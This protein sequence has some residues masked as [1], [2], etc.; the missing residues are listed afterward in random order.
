MTFGVSILYWLFAFF[1]PPHPIPTSSEIPRLQTE[2]NVG[3]AALEE[4]NLSEARRRFEA[5]RRLAPEEPLGW[6]DGAV[7]AMREK[8]LAGAK[9]L[10]AQALRLAP[11]DAR[12]LALQATLEE[13]EGNFPAAVEAAEK[14][15]SSSPRDLVSRWAAARVLSEKIAN[16]QPRALELL[17][18][19]LQEAPAN[20]FLLA[21]LFEL[22]L[23]GGDRSKAAATFE[24]LER[25]LEAETRADAK[26]ARYVSE[27]KSALDSG[28]AAAA[29]LK[30]RIVENLLRVLPRYQQARRDVDPAVVGLPLE[31]WSPAVAA[32]VRAHPR[33]IP[34]RFVERSTP[35]LAALERL[36]AVRAGGRDG[37]DLVFAGESGIAVALSRDSYRTGPPLPGSIARDVAVA[38]VA[39]SRQ[40]DLIT[41][42]G[43]WIGGR[44]SRKVPFSG[45]EHVLPFDYDND[46]DLDLY[47]TSPSGDRLWRNNLDG[48]WTDVTAAALPS[49]VASG[50]VCAADFDRDGDVDL[51][52][53]RAPG[54]LLLLNNLRG[55]RFAEREAG[56]PKTGAFRGVAA[57]D[58]NADGR[59]DIVWTTQ[60][61][62]FVALNRGDGTFL[63]ARE[64]A[65][66]GEPL[67][68]DFDNDGALD[69]FL[70][71]P[72][73]CSLWR[74]DGA[75]N[76]Q[77]VEGV[78][79]PAIAAE[80]V[81]FDGDGDLDLALVTPQGKALLLENQGGNANGWIDVA[82]EGLPTGSAKV[83]RFGYGSEVEIKAGQLYAFRT[84]SRAV[85]HVGVGAAR[86]ADVLRV[87][88]TNGIPQNKLSPPVQ[89]LVTEVQQL[90]GSCPFLYAF[91]GRRWSFV[92][93]ALGRAP[94]GLL[95]DGV[96]QAPADTREWL[97]VSGE[98]LAPGP[99]GKLLLD[100]TEELWETAY[101]DLAELEAVDHPKGTQIVPNEK[102]VP[103]PFPEKTLFTISH[104]FTPRAT[105][106]RGRDRT[107]EI[108]REDGT[109][110]AGFAPTRYQGIVEPHDLILRMLEARPGKRVMLYLT[111]WIFYADTSINVSLSQ[112]ARPEKPSDP[113]LEVP[114]GHGG[115]RIA[116]PSM[117]YPAGK[118]KTV[119]VD[120]TGLLDPAD[121]RVRIR[122]NLAIAWDRICYTVGE[123]PAPIRRA[124]LPLSA[125]RLF[126][127]GFS[128]M[129]RDFPD[130]P[131][132]FVHDDVD[133]SPRWADMAGL[134]T[135]LGDVRELLRSADD[136]YVVMKGGDAVR[137]EFDG[138]ALPPAPA[139][140]VRDWIV[141]LDGWDK[142]A[143]KNTVTAQTVEPL[144]FHGMDDTRYG[145][146]SQRYPE[147]AAHRRFREEY[148]TR[149][150]GPGEFI[151]AVRQS[152]RPRI[153][154]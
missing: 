127:R 68:F 26:L 67:L 2:K 8:N 48:T 42:N 101:F 112:G 9:S 37:R 132:V 125:A 135:R 84:V 58:V 110:L 140:W 154:D 90:K 139:G 148:L 72:K 43:L 99:E 15:A 52:L 119:P 86:K 130:G 83:N 73:G 55:G 46:G 27:T 20:L 19:A 32:A 134:Y 149:R 28:D 104:P 10:L 103:P 31:D 69:L 97:L 33:G 65:A 138:S 142:D 49:G 4:G 40:L 93:D 143:D 12:I 107:Q 123:E 141:T 29:S 87:I 118:T 74:N 100:F 105:D 53:A 126:V 146:P 18:A 17:S 22:E 121:P 95:Y 6:A 128:R 94:A 51:V 96:H 60:T 57:A 59:P 39:G 21:R 16:G 64:I 131:Q 23:Q 50:A 63:P 77:R 25:A 102:M 150:G 115:W 137:L 144:P 133:T 116:M 47:V 152:A 120:L 41:P 80:T 79:P 98:K 114:D 34:V 5:L 88:W 44:E 85:T 136:R 24:K 153:E 1:S 35:G 62:A 109:F 45:G 92:T 151:D 7:V 66:G 71:S 145:D 129:T 75:G 81:D 124:R 3:L 56:L 78:L 122:T 13:L 108:A 14:A 117:G 30:F 91:D 89:A 54:G 36:S 106:E 61:S 76:F 111:G 82:L 11:G 113:T 147:D 70:A 38:D